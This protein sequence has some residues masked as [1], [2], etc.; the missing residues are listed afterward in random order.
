MSSREEDAPAVIFK[1]EKPERKEA[2]AT[3]WLALRR[4]SKG[5]KGGRRE[6]K[7]EKKKKEGKQEDQ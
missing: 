6:E 2:R 7:R 4:D 1:K 5:R 3:S